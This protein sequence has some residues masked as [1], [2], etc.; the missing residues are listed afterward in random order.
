MTQPD[1]DDIRKRITERYNNR[2]AFFSHFVAFLVS[3]GF[4]W[5]LWFMT[6]ESVRSGILGVL[7]LLISVGWLIG[8]SIHA[9]IY[10]MMEARE[11]A[12]ERAIQDERAWSNG[13]KPK[14]DPLM[15]LTEDGELEELTDDDELESPRHQ[16]HR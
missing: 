5:S 9:I 15:R 7:L 3:N 11:H 14:R 8:M 12:I 4:G 6:P 10:L 1:Y 2:M 13:E 16:R